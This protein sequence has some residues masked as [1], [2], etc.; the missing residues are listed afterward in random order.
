MEEQLP[1]PISELIIFHT[2]LS[3]ISLLVGIIGLALI[4]KTKNKFT[5]PNFIRNSV[6]L[7]MTCLIISFLLWAK[8]PFKFDYMFGPFNLPTSVS[9]FVFL[10]IYLLM[11]NP[12]SL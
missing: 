11:L 1:T 2:Y 12:K 9:L 5:W 10:G 6:L 8:W 3:S 4:M 7:L